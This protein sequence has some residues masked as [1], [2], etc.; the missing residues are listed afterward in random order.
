VRGLGFKY[1][2]GKAD[3]GHTIWRN[4]ELGLGV[5]QR[6]WFLVEPFWKLNYWDVVSMFEFKHKL[7]EAETCV[8]CSCVFELHSECSK[9]HD[10]VFSFIFELQFPH[11]RNEPQN[12]SDLRSRIRE[13]ATYASHL[14]FSIDTRRRM[15]LGRSDGEAEVFFEDVGFSDMKCW[16]HE[17]TWDTKS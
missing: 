6:T 17:K 1:E 9:E 7:E 3:T 15:S 10:L 12:L 5:Q 14:V 16:Y 4:F 8:L 2:S 13:A 11:V